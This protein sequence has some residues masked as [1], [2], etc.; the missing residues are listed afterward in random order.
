MKES[1]S[2]EET[3][4]EAFIQNCP[5]PMILYDN[6][7]I[8]QC[9]Q[10]I[11]N[12]E[13]KDS[14]ETLTTID[15]MKDE[16]YFSNEEYF[17]KVPEVVPQTDYDLFVEWMK[18]RKIEESEPT[19]KEEKTE[20]NISVSSDEEFLE[21]QDVIEEVIKLEE[22]PEIKTE[23]LDKK[24]STNPFEDE[25]DLIP[26]TLLS[27]ATS[28]LTVSQ[29]SLT[30]SQNS[31]SDIEGESSSAGKRPVTHTKGRAP[32]PPKK[33][34]LLGYIPNIFRSETSPA[35]NCESDSMKETA[36]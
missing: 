19:L 3:E 6:S 36:I 29:T 10:N 27:V 20:D 32:E 30:P 26:S 25:E 12:L 33:K 1:L 23:V 18:T 15:E 5:Y 17:S 11:E 31:T 14:Q 16:Q 2:F 22:I 8:R 35:N 21:S 4:F 24:I 28:S 7:Y 13:R 9:P 34:S